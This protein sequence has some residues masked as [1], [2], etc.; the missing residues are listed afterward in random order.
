MGTTTGKP[1]WWAICKDDLVEEIFDLSS[2]TTGAHYFGFQGTREEVRAK[3]LEAFGKLI[4]P[5]LRRSSSY[6]RE[7]DPEDEEE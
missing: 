1:E 2:D 7:Y 5:M 3:M 4:D 6:G